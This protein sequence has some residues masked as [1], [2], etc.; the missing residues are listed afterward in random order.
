MLTFQKKLLLLLSITVLLFPALTLSVN[1]GI[2]LALIPMLLVCLVIIGLKNRALFRSWTQADYA[3]LFILLT[4]PLAAALSMVLM[5]NWRWDSFDNPSRFLL[6]IPVFLVIRHYGFSQRF[7]YIGLALGAIG[8]GALGYHQKF[9][10]GLEH[11]VGYTHKIPFGD[12]SLILG[13]LASTYL[14]RDKDDTIDKK[15]A[16]LILIAIPCGIVGS[17]CSGTRGG[18]IAMPFMAWLVLSTAIT[19]KRLLWS[20]YG[21]FLVLLVSVYFSSS[22]VNQK[23]DRAVSTTVDYFSEGKVQGSAGTRFEM[24]RA[25][26]LIFQEHPAFGSGFHTYKENLTT[27]MKEG[28]VDPGRPYAHAHNEFLNLL[29]EFGI[30]GGII[31]FTLFVL[32]III[33][34]KLR[35]I[36]L[37]YATAGILLSL[38][39]IEF[40]L[41][42]VML[43]HNISAT[44]YAFMLTIL[45]AGA[46]YSQ[47][48]FKTA[49]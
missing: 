15:L 16:L 32:P 14:I 12:I 19:N 44:F 21:T 49:D 42:Q 3:C 45:M 22:F 11:A 5:G 33:F 35:E 28:A 38:G 43:H 46:L 48:R 47:R 26:G 41:T 20:I 24:W 1:K 31:F 34:T 27:L 9:V 36:N 4:F 37:R 39:Y 25:A 8:A 30:I 29:A 40:G 18:W 10:L 23:I 13:A 17:L 2:G 6:A 7:L